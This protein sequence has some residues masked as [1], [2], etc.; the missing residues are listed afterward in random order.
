MRSLAILTFLTLDGVMQGPSSP[1]EDPSGGFTRGGW[2]ADYWGITMDSVRKEAMSTPYD[3]LFGRKTYELFAGHWPKADPADPD[4]RRLTEATKY[5]ATSSG[6]TY[7][8]DNTV[9]LDGDIPA[10]VAEL[11]AQDGPLIQIHG[12]G[13]LVRSLIEADLIDAFRLW[14]FPVTVG[15]G[16][17]LFGRGTPPRTL[18]LLKAEPLQNG[19]LMQIYARAR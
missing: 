5:I 10:R 6:K 8:W 13:E 3:M 11:K 12:S 1:Q 15:D 7:D 18:S 2:A 4:A 9:V 16:K 17:R 19:V 14:T